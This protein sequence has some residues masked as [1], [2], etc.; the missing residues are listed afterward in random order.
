MLTL[1]PWILLV[2]FDAGL[3]VWR[4][5]ILAPIAKFLYPGAYP[6][7]TSVVFGDEDEDED[8]DSGAMTKVVNGGGLDGGLQAMRELPDGLDRVLKEKDA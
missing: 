4:Y 7:E 6:S 5:L 8:E 3:Y 2:L 1:F